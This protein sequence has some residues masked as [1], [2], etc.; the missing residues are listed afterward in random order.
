MYSER[1]LVAAAELLLAAGYRPA[2]LAWAWHLPEGA[3]EPLLLRDYCPFDEAVAAQ[4]TQLSRW[5]RWEAGAGTLWVFGMCC[6]CV[7]VAVVRAWV[8]RG[9][10]LGGCSLRLSRVH[11]VLSSEDEPRSHHSGGLDAT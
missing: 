9:E 5:D 3:Q 8:D 1:R 11:K 10:S 6:V 2:R 4:G 7:C